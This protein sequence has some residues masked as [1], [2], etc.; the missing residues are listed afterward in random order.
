MTDL[1][2]PPGGPE[3]PPPDTP[4]WGLPR[5]QV[6]I[7]TLVLL[8]AVIAVAMTVIVDRRQST[9]LEARIRAMAPLAHEL[10]IVDVNQF[11]AVKLENLWMDD[12]RW[13]VYLPAGE[14]RLCVATREVG[15]ERVPRPGKSARIKSGRHRLELGFQRQGDLWPI[16]VASDGEELFAF[17]ESK[18]WGLSGSS[19]DPT[20]FSVSTQQS[21]GRPLILFHRRYYIM[22]RQGIADE[23]PTPSDGLILWIEPVNA[24]KPSP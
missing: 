12:N 23:P 24:P 6:G 17:N 14:Y 13:D 11:A 18:E 7:R 4:K 1:S 3:V 20:N 10:K 5:W 22:N 8:M 2:N 15:K 21:T 19:T 16:R 9:A